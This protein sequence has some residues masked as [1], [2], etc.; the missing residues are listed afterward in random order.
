M[1]EKGKVEKRIRADRKRERT[2]ADRKRGDKTRKDFSVKKRE[3]KKV[4]NTKR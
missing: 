3:D 1:G 4:G 2:K